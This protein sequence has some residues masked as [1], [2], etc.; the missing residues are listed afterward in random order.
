MKFSERLG[1]KYGI[2]F[3]PIIKSSTKLLK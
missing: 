1:E 3:K 2:E